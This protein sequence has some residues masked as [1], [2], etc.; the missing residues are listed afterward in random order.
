MIP[1][2]SVKPD[3][4][5]LKVKP[6]F[7]ADLVGGTGIDVTLA[8]GTFMVSLDIEKLQEASGNSGAYII[9]W[10]SAT[11]QFSR[12]RISSLASLIGP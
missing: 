1:F 6:Q 9:V 2:L 12:I 8:G 11:R 4:I 10:D 7:P 3:A 5:R